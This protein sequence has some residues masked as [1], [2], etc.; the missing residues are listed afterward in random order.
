MKRIIYI[1]SLFFL[2]GLGAC[3]KIQQKKEFT[4]DSE[5]K[6][7]FMYGNGSTWNYND[8]AGGPTL[9]SIVVEG[10]QE[11]IMDLGEVKQ[12]FFAYTLNCTGLKY[13]LLRAIADQDK[14]SRM[15][16]FVSDTSY[17]VAVEMFSLDG[18]FDV[19]RGKNDELSQFATKIVNG[20]TY[21]NVLEVDLGSDPFYTK[22]IYAKSIGIV[23]MTEKSGRNL[24]LDTY[25]L[26]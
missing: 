1:I 3:E 15:A 20:K 11:G 19:F 5:F 21:N 25:Q 22:I 10:Q 9:A 6:K 23:A 12:E 7:F 24:Y 13:M 18:V 16:L 2:L 4:L 17:K 14:I 26:K 8:G